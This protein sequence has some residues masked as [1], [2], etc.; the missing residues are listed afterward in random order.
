MPKSF[1][2]EVNCENCGKLFTKRIQPTTK[3]HYCSWD[4]KTADK[5]SFNSEWNEERRTKQTKKFSGQ[6]NP[7]FG[8]RWNEEQR[9][10]A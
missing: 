1:L 7:N 3:R 4:C 5:D 6:N 10:A 9:T 8:N 2:K